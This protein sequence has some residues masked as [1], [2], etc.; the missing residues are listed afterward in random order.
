MQKFQVVEGTS[1]PAAYAITA[2]EGF[3]FLNGEE[4]DGVYYAVFD[5]G[6]GT[7][8]FDFG[9]L[10]LAEDDDADFYDYVLTHF[11]AHGD[12][13]LGGENPVHVGGGKI[14]ICRFGRLN[15]LVAGSKPEH[16]QSYG[17]AASGL[18]GAR[19]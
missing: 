10:K 4:N 2:L 9:V 16:A 3:G 19:F 18:G 17:G 11:G 14:G 15:P 7:T 8:D 6:G 12:R 13:T 5:F 1:E